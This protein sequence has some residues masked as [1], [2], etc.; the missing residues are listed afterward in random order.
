MPMEPIIS[1]EKVKLRSG[2][3]MIPVIMHWTEKN[4]WFLQFAYS[5]P[6]IEDVKCMEGRKWHGFDDPPIKMW[7]IPDTPRNRFIL[8]HLK[9]DKP[10]T[11]YDCDLVDYEPVRDLRI[12]QIEM[13]DQFTF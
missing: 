2:K 5:P 11:R 7:S 1:S 6:L 10:Y 12:N 4:R 9:G 8:A 3:Y 13:V